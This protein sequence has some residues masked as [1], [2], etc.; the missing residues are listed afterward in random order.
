MARPSAVFRKN[1]LLVTLEPDVGPV[2]RAR[3]GARAASAL[4][5]ESVEQPFA[6]LEEDGLIEEVVAI[7]QPTSSA[8]PHRAAHALSAS[9]Q[10]N[11][12]PA[13]T[14]VNVVRLAP[15][16]SIEEVSRRLDRV[17]G[18]L[19][20][21]RVPVR[22]LV[23]G[24]RARP[25]A[26]R[27]SAARAA[28]LP[29]N[30]DAI[31]WRGSAVPSAARVKVAVLD[32]GVDE[33]HPDLEIASYE[34]GDVSAEDI[35]GHGTHVCGII[36][37]KRARRGAFHGGV[38]NAQLHVWKIFEDEPDPD[39]DDYLVD[40][41]LYQ[42]ALLAALAAGC[43]VLN[44][45]IGAEETTKAER[46]LM[47]R[48]T[49]GGVAVVAAMGNEYNDGNP[50]E[51]PAALT[52]V[53]AVGAVKADLKRAGFSNTGSHI[54]LVAPGVDILSTVPLR[55]SVAREETRYASWPGT[56]MAAPHVAAAA[57]RLLAR[58]A[59]SPAEVKS[60]LQ[61]RAKR[62]PGMGARDW[63]RVLGAGLLQV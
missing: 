35:I 25:V 60:E 50:T 40:E 10:P 36:S 7:A 43:K 12:D 15:G 6:A 34:H 22:R 4:G 55:A 46:R 33:S 38:S 41:A 20:I 61:A 45:S 32:S 11:V 19:D 59:L 39:E 58:R 57:A 47:K 54:A 31:G 51:Y 14:G 53:I 9:V 16:A 30:L 37:G 62:L 23:A 28:E 44:L 24:P 13:V 5:V 3:L 52:D 8:L 63:T 56:S 29:W 18:V 48:L 42:R 2:G 49:E 1:Q 27:A 21:E 17:P 26:A